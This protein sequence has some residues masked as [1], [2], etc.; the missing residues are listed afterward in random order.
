MFDAQCDLAAV[1]YDEDESPDDVLMLFCESL[2]S[3]GFR[4]VGLLQQGDCAGE[5]PGFSAILIHTNERISL[6]Q[7]LGSCANG[8]RLDIDQLLTAGSRIVT[9]VD[10]GADLVVVN[11]FG[12]L[13]RE[14]KGLTFLI[15]LAMSSSIPLIIA[16]PSHRF[17]DWVKFSDGMSVKLAC[18][19]A[20]VDHWWQSVRRARS[21]GEA[22]MP[23]PLAGAG[24]P[25]RSN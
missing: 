22:Q 12:R 9:A 1:V 8:C 20:S 13:E 6:S 17:A 23:G 3:S 7:D 10:H 24:A 4:P 25:Q 2:K 18:N 15:E 21:A 14:G 11:R 5:R 16:V 19:L